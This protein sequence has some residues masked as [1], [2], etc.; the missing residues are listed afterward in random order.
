MVVSLPC[1]ECT[2][3]Y[4]NNSASSYTLFAVK[5]SGWDATAAMAGI[6]GGGLALMGSTLL[7]GV[8]ESHVSMLPIP[9]LGTTLFPGET[10]A[11][12]AQGI[13]VVCL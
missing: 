7:P 8:I 3:A 10:C 1:Y 9:D 5:D 13:H 4:L 11:C 2:Q 12:C 6:P